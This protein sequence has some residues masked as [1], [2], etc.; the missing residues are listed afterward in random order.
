[1]GVAIRSYPKQG[2]IV[3][4]LR[5]TG[6]SLSAEERLNRRKRSDFFGRGTR[7]NATPSGGVRDLV[8]SYTQDPAEK[9]SGGG[10]HAA[11]VEVWEQGVTKYPRVI[12]HV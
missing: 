5:Y 9:R 7:A 3:S 1:M 10:A 11:M 12:D 6:A 2:A 8:P 4:R